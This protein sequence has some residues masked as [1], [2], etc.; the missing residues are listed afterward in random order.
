[1]N[2]D[3]IKVAVFI[4]WQ[5]TYKT[6]REAFGWRDFPNEYGN[7]SPYQLA[8]VLT[9]GNGRG[10]DAE[11]VRANVHRGLP[12]QKYDPKG[13]A[14]NRRQAAAWVKEAPEV[15]VPRL[16]PLR[17]SRDLTEPPREKGV[18]VELALEA[19]EWTLTGKQRVAVIFS[20]DTDLVPVVDMLCR[21][22]GP[23]CVETASWA[24]ASF[25]QRIRTR[26]DAYHHGVSEAVFARVE[27]RINYAHP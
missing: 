13:Y 9:A 5:N 10:A 17:Y 14:A 16:R 7:Y 8:R 19:V 21:L 24:S 23:T 1:M 25:N 2:A 3:A 26:A 6:A 27:T 20:H 4:D 22:K 15:V 11:L 18:D 12:S